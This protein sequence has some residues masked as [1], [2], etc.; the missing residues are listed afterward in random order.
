MLYLICGSVVVY[1]FVQCFAEYALP[2][3]YPWLWSVV[4]CSVL[5]C[6]LCLIYGSGL[7]QCLLSLTIIMVLGVL[8]CM[9]CLMIIMV[10]GVLQCMLLVFVPHADIV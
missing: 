5:L 6:M 2:Y 3:D 4:L 10:H 1:G 7:M 8:Q 9:L